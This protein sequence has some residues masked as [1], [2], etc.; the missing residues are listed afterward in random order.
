MYRVFSLVLFLLLTGAPHAIAGPFGGSGTTASLSHAT[1]CTA[2]GVSGQ[3]GQACVDLDDGKLWT[4]KTPSAGGAPGVCDSPGDW[5]ATG[6]T[7]VGRRD[8]YH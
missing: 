7:A 2:G 8:L 4:C 5:L 6:F 3:L 1:D